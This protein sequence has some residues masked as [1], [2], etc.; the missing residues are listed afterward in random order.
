MFQPLHSLLTTSLKRKSVQEG[1]RAAV[2]LDATREII[3]ALFP[4]EAARGIIPKAVRR[5][6]LIL[7][8]RSAPLA[9]EIKLR[10]R[11]ILSQLQERLNSTL[12]TR[13]RIEFFNYRQEDADM[14]R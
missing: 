14:L 3:E 5:E 12:V 1:I 11:A 6:V 2:I 4:P 10:S 13:I 8:V 7:A 9:Q